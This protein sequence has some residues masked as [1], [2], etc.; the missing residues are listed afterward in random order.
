[1]GLNW[2]PPRKP[3]SRHNTILFRDWR[4][5]ISIGC[6][7][8]RELPASRTATVSFSSLEVTWLR[9]IGV[10]FFLPNLSNSDAMKNDFF[11]QISQ[12]PTQWKMH[13]SSQ[14]N[15]TALDWARSTNIHTNQTALDWAGPTNIHTN[16]TA[17]DW[18]GP[19]NIHTEESFLNLVK[20]N[21]IK[22][23]PFS[24]ILEIF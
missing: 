11:F 12:I 24:W 14:V 16:Q 19:T 18:A 4:G 8:C 3:P 5:W 7:L 21:Q 22:W 20:L 1:M 9:R 17:L 13:R 15:Q 23:E 6:P 2:G 10:E